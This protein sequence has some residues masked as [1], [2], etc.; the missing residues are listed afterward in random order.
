MATTFVYLARRG[1]AIALGAALTGYSAWASWAHFYDPLGP[2]A[3]ISAAILLAL[4]EHSGHD[5]HR[6]RAGILVVLGLAA[7][8]ISG[9]VVLERVSS[10]QEARLQSTRSSNLPRVEA[11]NV[12]TETKEALA[13]AEA[14]AKAECSSGRGRRC[15]A[16]EQREQAARQRVA[17]ARA[18][19]VGFGAQTV[20]NPAA[21]A[22]A[23]MIGI[24]P[25]TYQLLLPLALPLW[26]ELAAPAVLAYG[27]APGRRKAPEPKKKAKR[28]KKKAAPR[29]PP[30]K[31]A[32]AKADNVLPLFA[33]KA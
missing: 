6:F 25:A 3:A 21:L 2:L 15:D 28:R 33:K 1:V 27:F 31:K 4:A 11:E 20:E 22:V 29:K 10:T 17:E 30:A 23:S 16:L 32:Q 14:A 8:I 19:L 9:S 26:L 18:G 7:A 5:R 12:V 24:S 13:A